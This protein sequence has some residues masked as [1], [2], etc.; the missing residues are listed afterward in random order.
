MITEEEVKNAEDLNGARFTFNGNI[1][2]EIGEESISNPT[3][4]IAELIK[5]SYDADA[6]KVDIN[7]IN[8]GKSNAKIVIQDDGVGMDDSQIRDRWMDIGSPHKR[9]LEETPE[10]HRIPVGAKGIGRFAS[11]CLGR[12]LKLITA[13]KN[14]RIGHRLTFD[15][16]KYSPNVKA[17]DIDNQMQKFKK[18]L[19]TRGTT[20]V[21]ENLKYDWNENQ[22]I[23]GL[24]TDLYL[25]PSPIE[26]PKNFKIK[27]H[28]DGN[29][30]GIPKLT[31]EFLD[32]AGYHLHV[33]LI[34]KKEAKIRFF[35]NAKE[36]KT[37]T[38]TLDAEL[39]CGDITFDLYFYY[40]MA[41]KWEQYI[42]KTLTAGE[43]K[44]I[45]EM[46]N[47][48]GGI[49]L[50][51]DRFRVKP[52]GDRDADWIGLDKWS[53]DNP[54]IIPGNTQV[55]GIVSISKECNPKIEDTTSREGV[56][57][58]KEF[59]DLVSFVTT[60][61]KIFIDLRSGEEGTKAKAKRKKKFKVV[62]PKVQEA[63]VAVQETQFIDVNGTFPTNHYNQLV[64]EANESELRNC[65]NAAFWL[66]RKMVENLI[67]D[68]LAKK[69]RNQV[70]LWYDRNKHRN[71][72]LSMLIDNMY[73]RKD[74]FNPDATQYIE[75]FKNDV[76]KFKK[77]VDAAVHKNFFYLNDKK[78]LKPYKVSKLIQLL[79]QIYGTL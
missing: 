9:D 24:L 43:V 37:D 23:K 52:Y 49:K 32:K 33:E 36:V 3:I 58:R 10:N 72:S 64:N 5:N 13:S 62:R 18:K 20:L 54:S 42:R 74:D 31:S 17:T 27:E 4:A 7:F 41:S 57:N 46:L 45:G 29:I 77:D 63:P 47:Y 50:Y 25:L 76:G 30:T 16:D 68:I 51:R 40:K 28:I 44:E 2:A 67:F 12:K 66:S 8:L 70:D 53:R 60:S 78:E 56:I 1:I 65:P 34:H 11:H 35:K 21:I 55:I 79:L 71:H 19:S 22:K 26:P 59:F 39:S 6:K 14:E 69:Y 48:Y 61:I 75:Q 15:W 38:V 73:L